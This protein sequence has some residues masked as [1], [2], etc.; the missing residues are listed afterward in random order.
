MPYFHRVKANS[1]SDV[2]KKTVQ[3]YR[4]RSVETALSDTMIPISSDVAIAITLWK[5]VLKVRFH[6]VKAMWIK[7]WYYCCLWD[8]PPCESNEAIT[9]AFALWKRGIMVYFHKASGLGSI[10]SGYQL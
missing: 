7:N 5:W 2:T 9:I 1:D 10:H 4:Y 8:F 3:T 6:R